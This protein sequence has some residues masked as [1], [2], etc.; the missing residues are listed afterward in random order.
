MACACLKTMV[1][2]S[3]ETAKELHSGIVIVN[4]VLHREKLFYS[5]RFLLQVK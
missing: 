1:S 3:Q 5:K 4:G 2:A